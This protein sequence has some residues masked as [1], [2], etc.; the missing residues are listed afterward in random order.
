ME[1]AEGTDMFSASAG[2]SNSIAIVPVAHRALCHKQ[3]RYCTAGTVCTSTARGGAP[4]A[5][6]SRQVGLGICS[7]IGG[8]VAR[9]SPQR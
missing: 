4:L 8:G 3:E 1:T 7:S 9:S 2:S 5:S 6:A